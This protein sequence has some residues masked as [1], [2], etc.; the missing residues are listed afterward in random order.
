MKRLA[1]ILAG[2]LLAAQA[3]ALTLRYVSV[4][5]GGDGTSSGSPW[6]VFDR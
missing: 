6:E 3:N 1:L 2:L 4:A 5:G